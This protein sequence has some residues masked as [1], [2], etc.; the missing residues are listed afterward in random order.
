MGSV[1]V[2]EQ[3]KDIAQ[4]FEVG[5]GGMMVVEGMINLRMAEEVAAEEEILVEEHAGQK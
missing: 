2:A 3:Q 1:A 4:K 5:P